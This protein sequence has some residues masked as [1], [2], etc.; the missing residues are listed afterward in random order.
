M[1]FNLKERL[2]FTEKKIRKL[3]Y[4]WLLLASE[5]LK[6]SAVFDSSINVILEGVDKQK[7]DDGFKASLVKNWLPRSLPDRI[8]MIVTVS[9]GSHADSYFKTSKNCH[10]IVIKSTMNQCTL[11]KE[12][13]FA[14]NQFS[15]HNHD[16]IQCF[17]RLGDDQQNNLKFAE[18]FF[19]LFLEKKVIEPSF[20]GKLE[21]LNSLIKELVKFEDLTQLNGVEDM[22]DYAMERLSKVLSKSKNVIFYLRVPC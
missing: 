19:A 7:E 1:K 2:P 9:E 13:I 8:N 17:K 20:E 10:R 12:S 6:K 14:L 21:D 16:V 22:L 4:F 5:K 18:K 3:F 15:E 11:L